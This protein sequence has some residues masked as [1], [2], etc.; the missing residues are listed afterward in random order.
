MSFPPGSDPSARPALLMPRWELVALVAALMAL[1]ALAIDVFIPV[2]Q[3]IGTTLQVADENRRQFV[4][5]AYVLGFGVAQLV[6]GPL[7]DRYGRRPVLLFG[8][9]VYVAAS[10]AAV[11]APTFDSLL[12]IRFI[13]GVGTAA[14]RVVAISVV[15]DTFGGARMARIMS[16]VMMVFMAVPL[17]APNVGQ[18]IILFGDWQSV[19]WVT[20]LL[21]AVMAVWSFARLPET[22]HPEYRLPLT[23]TKVAVA[24]RTV[25]TTRAAFGYAVATALCFAVLFGFIN[26]AEQLLTHTFG[27]GQYFTL[28]FTGIAVF[29]AG[30]SLMNAQLVERLGMRWLSHT[31]LMVFAATIMLA[32]VLSLG[33]GARLP[34]ALFCLLMAVIFACFGFI[35]TNF[36]ALAMDPLAAVAGTASSVLGF[37]QAF[38][39]GVLGAAI[40]Y[41][42]DGTVVPLFAGYL[43]LA[44]GA[45]VCVA[46]AEG[47][48]LFAPDENAAPPRA[49]QEAD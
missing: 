40:G 25:V 7:A 15:R 5:G 14:T 27:L 48:W 2:L 12:A 10:A 49:A 29:M 6:Y 44:L 31:A 18:A 35:G 23:F 28:A 42:Y 41:L 24:F 22:L 3:E 46:V 43:M 11:Y 8:L 37:L 9:A 36:N 13:Q 17:I 21:G 38:V 30:T 34:F 16:L 20:G 45:I 19:F 1:N 33:M 39:G 4:I 32:L 26:Q 47:G